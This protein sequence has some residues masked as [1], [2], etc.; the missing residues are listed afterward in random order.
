MMWENWSSGFRPGLTQTE[1][2]S[3]RKRLE[4]SNSGFKKK[5]DCTIHVAKTTADLRLFSDTQKSGFLMMGLT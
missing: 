3:L 5:R 2:Y 4:D 1:L